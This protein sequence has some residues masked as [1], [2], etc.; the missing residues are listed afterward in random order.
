MAL[1]FYVT[2]V[3]QF[4]SSN[5][6]LKCSKLGTKRQCLKGSLGKGG[7]S[8]LGVISQGV[9]EDPCLPMITLLISILRSL[10]TDTIIDADKILTLGFT[11]SSV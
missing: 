10:E 9:K 5:I 4:F 11:A 8:G 1:C 6:C 7:I 3:L 2:H